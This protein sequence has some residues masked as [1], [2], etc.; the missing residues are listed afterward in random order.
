[1]KRRTFIVSSSVGLISLSGCLWFGGD[2]ETALEYFNESL[3]YISTI[4]EGMYEYS[5][6][7]FISGF[8][9]MSNADFRREITEAETAIENAENHATSDFAPYIENIHIIIRYQ[10][11]L[12]DVHNEIN[13]LVEELDELFERFS[14]DSNFQL[15]SIAQNTT[16]HA[17]NIFDSHGEAI[18]IQNNISNEYPNDSEFANDDFHFPVFFDDSF[19]Q[20]LYNVTTAITYIAT[21]ITKA[22]SGLETAFLSENF[23]SA[24]EDIDDALEA[25]NVANEIL[26]DD[27]L[28]VKES[29]VY[30]FGERENSDVWC[31]APA[32]QEAIRLYND[33]VIEFERGNEQEAEELVE[34][35]GEISN[36]CN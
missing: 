12:I 23:E 26:D 2:D 10:Q 5:E 6:S 20:K 24:K 4:D 27:T 11:S 9:G 14:D 25:I 21:A 13:L 36:G 30:I 17:E 15:E 35:A 29:N 31:L 28:K 8:D 16:I 22:D 19:T 32:L 33:A 18:D 7:D 1:M 3:Q 34:E